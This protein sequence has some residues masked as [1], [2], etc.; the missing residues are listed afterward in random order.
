MS[1]M[2]A[3][4]LVE[5]LTGNT[6]R[7]AERIAG[8]LSEEGWSITGL[9]RVRR[10]DLASIQQ[11]DVVL[12]GTWTHGLFVVGQAPWA[13]AEIANLPTMRGKRIDHATVS[14]V[15]TEGRSVYRTDRQE[16]VE[17]HVAGAADP[18]AAAEIGWRVLLDGKKLLRVEYPLTVT[19][20]LYNTAGESARSSIR[21]DR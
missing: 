21:V 11:A 12:V 18:A 8:G 5:S 2:K 1:A 3:A 10:P 17:T 14:I 6:T 13:A 20:T 7:S 16:H 15:D 19:V 9:S 4:L